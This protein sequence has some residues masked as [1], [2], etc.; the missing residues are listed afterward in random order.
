MGR[1]GIQFFTPILNPPEAAIL[2]IGQIEKQVVFTDNGLE[3]RA[4]LPLSLTFDHRIVDGAPAAKF[5]QTLIRLLD[6][7]E[8]LL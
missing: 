2:G 7:P 5:L 3:Q 4:R 8:Q 1:F 6:E